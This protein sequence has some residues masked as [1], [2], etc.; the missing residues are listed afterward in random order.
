M[1]MISKIIIKIASIFFPYYCFVC[2]KETGDVAIC[3][4]CLKCLQKPIDTPAPYITSLYSFKNEHI[5]KAIHGIKYFHRKDL[6]ISFAILLAE[7]IKEDEHYK[8]YILVP[9]PMPQFRKYIRGYNHT[10]VLAKLISTSLDVPYQNNIL[11]QNRKVRNSRQVLTQSRSERLQ[12][13]KNTFI[14]AQNIKN[15]NIILID[16]VTTTGATLKEARRVL[17]QAGASRVMA[18]TIAH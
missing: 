16:D 17:L 5:K 15:I 18:F 14:V 9:I 1:W 8:S 12:N 6:L 10:E 4:D 2:K 13:K 7:T 11:L 3:R